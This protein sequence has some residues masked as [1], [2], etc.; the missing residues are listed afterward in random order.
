[1]KDKHI[2]E[3]LSYKSTIILQC[4]RFFIH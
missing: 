1:V 3:R 2:E 4:F